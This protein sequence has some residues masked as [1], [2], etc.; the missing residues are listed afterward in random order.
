MASARFEITGG[1]YSRGG[2]AAKQ[3][4]KMLKQIDADARAVR[5][6]MVA[7]YEAEMN[8]VIHGGDGFMEVALTPD[9]VEVVIE[10]TGPGIPDIE[11]AL[12]PGFS[13]APDDAREMGFGAGMGLPNIIK[14]SDAFTIQSEAGAGVRLH[15]TVMLQ[16]AGGKIRAVNS[17]TAAADRCLRCLRCLP[18]CPTGAIRVRESRPHI[19]DHLCVDCSTCTAVCPAAVYDMDAPR[20]MPEI[21]E[22]TVLTLPV[23]FLAQFGGTVSPADV[24]DTLEETGFRKILLSADQEAALRAETIRLAAARKEPGPLLA[25]VCP[26]VLNL[27]E[28]RFPAL[29]GHLAPLLSPAEALREAVRGRH[30]VHVPACPAENTILSAPAVMTRIDM[31]HPAFLREAVFK[32]LRHHDREAGGTDDVNAEDSSGILDIYGMKQVMVFLDHLENGRIKDR[33]AAALYACDQGCFGAPVWREEPHIARLRMEKARPFFRGTRPHPVIETGARV[34]RRTKLPGS[35]GGKRLDDNMAEAIRKL[36][37]ISRLTRI[38][39]GRDCGVC[40]A[41]DCAALAE[42]VILGRAMLDDCLF[43]EEHPRTNVQERATG[44][45]PYNDPA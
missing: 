6:T 4:K 27:I 19:F 11:K 14:N 13:T 16:P 42:D 20:R 45:D 2:E 23:A 7:A 38:L 3:L 36:T 37:E 28:T 29:I 41:P 24:L 21:S 43:I 35:R 10:D 12:L 25:P 34:Y 8:S 26:A 5:R 30:A 22:D 15:F 32:G 17:I 40:G 44:K 31:T 39:P 33:L 18:A 9:Q 1:D